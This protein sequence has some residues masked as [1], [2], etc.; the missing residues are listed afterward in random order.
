MILQLKVIKSKTV[1]ITYSINE[2]WARSWSRSLGSQPAGDLVINPFVS[3]RY[4]PPGPWLLFPAEEH[5]RPV[6]R[7]HIVWW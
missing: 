2:R 1:V 5:H 4:F 3:C 6:G 7:Y